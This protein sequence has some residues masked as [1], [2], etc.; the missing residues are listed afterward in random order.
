MV[1]ASSALPLLNVYL[2]SDMVI[3]NDTINDYYKHTVTVKAIFQ[4]IVDWYIE[5]YGEWL[6]EENFG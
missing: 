1:R 6:Y 2:S 5:F 3:S 4:C